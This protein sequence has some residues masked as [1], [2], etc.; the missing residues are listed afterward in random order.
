MSC[1]QRFGGANRSVVDALGALDLSNPGFWI[2]AQSCNFGG[3][4][5]VSLDRFESPAFVGPNQLTGPLNQL[6]VGDFGRIKQRI[7]VQTRDGL[8]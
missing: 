4:A 8:Q 1:H 5:Q 2:S 7:G 6:D 3:W